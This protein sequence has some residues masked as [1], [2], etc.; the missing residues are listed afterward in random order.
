MEQD[1]GRIRRYHSRCASF[2]SSEVDLLL[3]LA[4]EHQQLL[5][6]KN[7]ADLKLKQKTWEM[8]TEQFNA[9][10]E[11]E[12]YRTVKTLRKRYDN[13]QYFKRK[14]ERVTTTTTT[15]KKQPIAKIPTNETFVVADSVDDNFSGFY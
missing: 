3:R 15:E 4:D 13:Y 8:I 9:E 5:I 7:R 2:S 1:E 11:Q 6:G 10:S 12:E 14:A